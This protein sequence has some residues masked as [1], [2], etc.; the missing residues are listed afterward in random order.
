MGIESLK[1]PRV[2]LK[3]K[4]TGRIHSHTPVMADSN[5]PDDHSARA[6]VTNVRSRAKKHW[7]ADRNSLMF[8]TIRF[9]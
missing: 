2:E 6:C 1:S 8:L 5:K 9:K 4:Q 7:L 3:K